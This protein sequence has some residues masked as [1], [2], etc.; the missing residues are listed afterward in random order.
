MSHSEMQNEKKKLVVRRGRKHLIEINCR[1][2][3]FVLST[4]IFNE[5]ITNCIRNINGVE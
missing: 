1:L 5:Q 2:E 4:S 3:F